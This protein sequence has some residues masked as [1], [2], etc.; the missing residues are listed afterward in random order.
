MD[1]TSKLEFI[2]SELDNKIIPIALAA[3]ES[4]KRRDKKLAMNLSAAMFDLAEKYGEDSDEYLV[5]QAVDAWVLDQIYEDDFR[6][7]ELAESWVS[8]VFSMM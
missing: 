1:I 4:A 5:A 6:L 7:N 2:L 3:F 8:L